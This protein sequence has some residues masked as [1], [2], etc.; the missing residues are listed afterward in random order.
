MTEKLL[1]GML[2]IYTNKQIITYFNSLFQV[3]LSDFGFCAQ[4]SQE[5]PKRKSLVGTPYWMAP[6][7]ISR[8]PYGPEVRR[9]KLLNDCY[10]SVYIRKFLVIILRF[11]KYSI[12]LESQSVKMKIKYEK[13][14]N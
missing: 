11:Q 12:M 5:L 8:L 14:V 3:K 6:E 4:V 9:E 10:C 13:P 2:S 1:T 7:V